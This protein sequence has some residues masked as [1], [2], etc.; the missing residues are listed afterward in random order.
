MMIKEWS[1]DQKNNFVERLVENVK[2]P[3]ELSR[4]LKSL[5]LPNKK[6]PPSNI[7]LKKNMVYHLTHFE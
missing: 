7:S 3:I 2:K 1:D 5:A 6:T 4:A